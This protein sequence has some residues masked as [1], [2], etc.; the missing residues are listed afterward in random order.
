VLRFFI[1]KSGKK[2]FATS[3][4]AVEFFTQLIEKDLLL[5]HADGWYA[6]QNAYPGM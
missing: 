4:H 6:Y 1:E 2:K 5:R 3:A